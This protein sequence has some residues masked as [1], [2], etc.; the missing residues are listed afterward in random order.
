MAETVQ[1]I[2]DAARG[3]IAEK[4]A[5]KS[6]KP[7]MIISVVALQLVGA[8]F[9]VGFLLRHGGTDSQG[10]TPSTK[11]VAVTQR[12]GADPSFD[13]VYIVKDLIV[14]PAGTNGLRFLLTTVGLEV[15]S[16]ETVKELE[17]RDV[18]IHDSIIGILSS[19][20]LPELDEAV[21]RDSLKISIKSQVNKELMTG[22]V[23]NVYFS[24]FIIQ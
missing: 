24:K 19:K 11:Q 1:Q 2:A 7:F 20:T 22:S 12:G 5:A 4:P 18:Q 8:Y 6:K 9:L 14:N 13:H 3:T 10:A 21:S 16:E 23:I 17:K 15:T